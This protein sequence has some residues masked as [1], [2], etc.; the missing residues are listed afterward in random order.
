MKPGLLLLLLL[1]VCLLTG[2]ESVGRQKQRFTEQNNYQIG[3]PFFPNE[4]GG[5]K[6][7]RISATVS[8]FVPM[9]IPDDRAVVAWTVDIS[10][11]GQ[12][13]HPTNGMTFEIEGIK[14]SWRLLG[15]PE[16][17]RSKINWWGPW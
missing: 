15:A 8:E 17:A 12:W 13:H 11:R 3:R 7:V 4:R 10:Q 6:E 1:G 9:V 16:K 2:C 14:K 5:T